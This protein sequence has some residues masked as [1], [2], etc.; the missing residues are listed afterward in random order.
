MATSKVV[1]ILGE[2][3]MIEMMDDA[4]DDDDN[5]HDDYD[6]AKD[7]NN[8]DNHNDIDD[9]EGGTGKTGK[10][11]VKGALQKGHNVRILARNPDKV[12]SSQHHTFTAY[13]HT[14]DY[15]SIFIL[16]TVG[17]NE[18]SQLHSFTSGTE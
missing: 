14:T 12:E 2:L 13:I 11:G 8:G 7:D 17:Q 10:F 3:M 6:D 15:W 5:N 16:H 9:D 18:T 1:A 4:F